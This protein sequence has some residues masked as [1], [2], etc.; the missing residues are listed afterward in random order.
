MTTQPVREILLTRTGR[1][2]L[3]SRANERFDDDVLHAFEIEL[4]EIGYVPSHRLRDRLATVT[5]DELA[6]FRAWLLHALRAHVGANERHEPLFR[7]FPDRIPPDTFELWV[8]KVLAHFLQGEGQPC[9]FCRTKGTTHVL[10]PCQHVVCDRCFDGASYS[11]CPV[12]EHHIDR[13]TPFLLPSSPR[14]LPAERVTFK[15]LDLGDDV[16]ADAR[17][18]FHALCARKQALSPD[19][20]AALTAVAQLDSIPSAIPVRENIAIIFGTLFQAKDPD[21]VLTVARR[22]MTSATDVLRFLAV[23]S[24]ADASLQGE[25]T[26]RRVPLD[27]PL[28]GWSGKPRALLEGLRAHRQPLGYAQILRKRFRMARLRRSH[29]RALLA[30]LDGIEREKLIEDM[31]RHR[32]YWVWAGEFLHPGEYAARFPNVAEAFAVVRGEARF[33]TYAARVES[34]AFSGDRDALVAL[35]RARPGELARRFD[36]ALRTTGDAVLDLF[37]ERLPAFATPVLLTLASHLRTRTTRAALRVYFPKGSAA[38]GVIGVDE[39][40]LLPAAAVERATSGIHRELLRRF[41]EHASFDDSIVD[42]SLR[43]VIV[44]FNE[45]TASP[46]AVNLPRGSRIAVPDTK[47]ARLF[48][49][50]CEPPN[51]PYSTDIDLS[52]GFYDDAWNHVGVCS[53]YEL[54]LAVGDVEIATS[55]GDLRDAPF[56]DGATELIDLHRDRARAA[57]YRYAVMVVNNYSG[58]PFSALERGFAGLMLRDDAAGAQFDPRTVALKFAV[59]GPNGVYLPLVFDLRDSSIHWLDVQSTGG[60]AF[61]N[62]RTSNSAIR[63]ICPALMTYFASGA[64][65]SMFDLA[66]LHA[67]A[68]CRR[69]FVRGTQTRVFVRRTDED[70]FAFHARI[71]RGD[72]DPAQVRAL[73][74]PVFAALFRGDLAVPAGSTVYALFRDGIIAPLAAS[75][76]LS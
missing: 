1:V 3:D 66:L 40:P 23:I 45:R 63:T 13:D 2:F 7:S 22:Y 6:S 37:E 67:A 26:Y 50:W 32:S 47:L 30:V 14:G 59:S 9:L 46:S 8:T 34:A 55:A 41:G 68:R 52:V 75:D 64:R 12:C 65:P 39:R 10:S 42:E 76:L 29:R 4:A 48:L 27:A 15:L 25:L 49:H 35:L 31:L 61:N 21:E 43:D 24:G 62:V 72:G 33:S 19:D 38:K 36:H 20:R 56:P 44:P 73:E 28:S 54:R 11:A 71:V 60:L 51:S 16:D 58:L 57:G 53:Y 74:A 18:L 69:V 70:A 17:S 5:R